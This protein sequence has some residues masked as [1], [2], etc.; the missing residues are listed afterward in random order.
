MKKTLRLAN[1]EIRAR[2]LQLVRDA[3]DGWYVSIGPEG[4][5]EEQSR[6]FHAICGDMERSGFLWAGKRPNARQIKI[7]LVSAHSVATRDDSELIAGFEGEP[8]LIR[9]STAQMSRER[10]GSLIDY[11]LAFCAHN[12][13]DLIGYRAVLEQQ[14][15][16]SSRVSR[17]R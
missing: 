17:M 14:E 8:V 6:L 5:S 11:T 16:G 12:K 13:I 10:L 4:R 15:S 2:A 1:D 3:P 9:E 7:L